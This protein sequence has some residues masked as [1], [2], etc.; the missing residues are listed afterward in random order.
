MEFKRRQKK[1]KLLSITEASCGLN[2]TELL[3]ILRYFHQD[4]YIDQPFF[5]ATDNEIP[6]SAA[7]MKSKGAK[8]IEERAI[9]ENPKIKMEIEAIFAKSKAHNCSYYFCPR[10][11]E[12]ERLVVVLIDSW[13]LVPADYFIGGYFSTMSET[14]CHWRGVENSKFSNFCFL[15]NRMYARNDPL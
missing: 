5:L 11:D 14:V 13:A 12:I 7:E 1:K 3:D 4:K 9:L 8:T 2:Y 15:P 10:K 6:P